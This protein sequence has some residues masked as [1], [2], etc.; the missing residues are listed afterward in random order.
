MVEFPCGVGGACVGWELHD[1][2]AGVID[3]GIGKPRAIWRPPVGNVRLQ[4][5]L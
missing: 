4:N 1:G 5:L 3:G 2:H